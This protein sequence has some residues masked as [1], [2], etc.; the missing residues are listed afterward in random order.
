MDNLL[1]MMD[2]DPPFKPPIDGRVLYT[3]S[4]GSSPV[5]SFSSD[6]ENTLTLPQV[7]RPCY[8]YTNYIPSLFDINV[9]MNW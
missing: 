1:D 7:N 8:S 4:P 2:K 5:A 6:D 3:P 9:E